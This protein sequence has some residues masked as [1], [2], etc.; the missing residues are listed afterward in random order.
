MTDTDL[1]EIRHD[2]PVGRLR[3]VGGDLGLRAV[4][5]PLERDGR[6]RLPDAS[7]RSH[8]V[9]DDARRQLDEYFAGTRRHFD[10]PLDLRGT[11]F[12]TAVWR[13]LIDI[14]Y[15]ETSTY[16]KQAVGLGRPS[17]VRAVAG[18][19]GRNPI[20]IVVPCHRVVGADGSLTGFAGGLDAKQHLLHHERTH[21]A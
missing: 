2:S 13:S 5:W 12:Q 7:G 9:L 18:A 10:L 1:Y 21:H 4:L 16:A 14:T 15:G 17:A 6:V 19:I 11:E 8:P 3:L 20:S